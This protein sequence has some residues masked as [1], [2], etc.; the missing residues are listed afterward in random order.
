[1]CK[2]FKPLHIVISLGTVIIYAFDQITSWYAFHKYLNNYVTTDATDKWLMIILGCAASIGA[3]M[4][5]LAVRNMVYGF[6][7]FGDDDMEDAQESVG[8]WQEVHFCNIFIGY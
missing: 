7:A 3:V 8:R 2:G 5:I 6:K 4:L 1:M